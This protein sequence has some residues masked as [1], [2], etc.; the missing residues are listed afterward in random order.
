MN[1][2]V[3]MGNYS[4]KDI[5]TLTG[6]KAHTLRVWEQRYDFLRPQRTETNIRYYN[7]EQ[8]RLILNISMLNKNGFKISK[9]AS[10]NWE[11]MQKEVLRISSIRDEPDVLLD[12]LIHAMIDF[13]ESRFE[14]T[15]SQSILKH[16]FENTFTYVVFPMM[17]RT[18]ILWA[19]GVVRPAQEHFISNLIRRK[20]CVAIDSLYVKETPSTKRFVLFLPEGETHEL[21]L[22]FTEFML[23]SRNHHVVY[24][25][26]SLPFDDI[27]FINKAFRPQY[28]VTYVTVPLS[29][30]S[31]N[32]YLQKLSS[33]FPEVKILVGGAQVRQQRLILPENVAVIHSVQNLLDEIED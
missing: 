4:I 25:G 21:L 24:L 20:L 8:L 1:E 33:G 32:N 30:I 3:D 29:G 17:E 19:T 12:S 5:E 7:D 23:R 28:M 13:D 11:D 14:K 18:G 2:C 10:M 31:L 15:L 26:N 6:I 27:D 9:I 22:L 16:G